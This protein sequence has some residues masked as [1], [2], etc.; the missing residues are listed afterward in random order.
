ME[1]GEQL[2]EGSRI[3]I[4]A[5]L[6]DYREPTVSRIALDHSLRA[7]LTLHLPTETGK[8]LSEATRQHNLDL[9][10]PAENLVDRIWEDRPARTHE[11][12]RV[13]PLEFTGAWLLQGGDAGFLRAF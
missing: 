5:A 11:P 7:E 8:S 10:F 13:H 12:I 9:V 3:G 2:D 4:D 6:L 1:G